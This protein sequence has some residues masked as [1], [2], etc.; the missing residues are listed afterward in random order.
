[1]ASSEQKQQPSV[2]RIVHY[3]AYNGRCLAAI[4]IGVTPDS[5]AELVNLAIFTDM[6]NVVG[7]QA[8]GL[9][10]HFG[11]ASSDGPLPGYWHWPER[12]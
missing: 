4:I 6:P 12:V 10:F 9:Q 8:G 2:G 7:N 1:M 3:S 5:V 11:V